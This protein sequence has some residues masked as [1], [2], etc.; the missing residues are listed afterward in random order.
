MTHNVFRWKMYT[1]NIQCIQKVFRPL[2]FFHIFLCCGLMLKSFKYIFPSLIYT[3]YHIMTKQKQDFRT[4]WEFIK[5]EK[6]KSQFIYCLNT[7]RNLKST[8]GS[9]YSLESSWVWR[10]KLCTPGFGDFLPFFSADPLKGNTCGQSLQRFSI[11]FKSV[12]WL[13]HSRTFTELS[14]SHSCVVLAV[15]LGSL[16]CWKVN[17][18]LSLGSWALWTKF[19][20]R[21]SLCF[22]PS[23][24]PS[25]LTL[26]L[27]P[28][29]E[30]HPTACMMLPAPSFTIGMVLGRW[31]CLEL[32]PYS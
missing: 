14:L 7:L 8:S 16:S 15:C 21:I 25:T 28:A 4:F 23:S 5:K 9:D 29:T 6:L 11:G 2:H 26:P 24:F 18:R 22:A 17:H 31:W 30:K 27:V 3:Q 19:S 13:G 20:L 12:L 10:D 32:R 1:W